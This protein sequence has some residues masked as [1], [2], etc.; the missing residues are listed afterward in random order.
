LN[1]VLVGASTVMLL[2]P[3]RNRPMLGDLLRALMTSITPGLVTVSALKGSRTDSTTQNT[4]SPAVDLALGAILLV[5][6]WCSEQA[7]ERR[8]PAGSA[9]FRRRTWRAEPVLRACCCG[10]S[11][12]VGCSQRLQGAGLTLAVLRGA[13]VANGVA[14]LWS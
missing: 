1:P 7:R 9:R 12:S 11:E 2:L 3:N 6:P 14:R 4:T 5:A 10:A 8:T 13:L